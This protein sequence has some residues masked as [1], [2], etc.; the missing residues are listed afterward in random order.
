[1]V[2]EF[3]TKRNRA[4]NTEF[5]DPDVAKLKIIDRIGTKS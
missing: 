2:E 3:K 4:G 1:M 5:V